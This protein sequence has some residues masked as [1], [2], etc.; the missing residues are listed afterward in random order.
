MALVKPVAPTPPAQRPSVPPL[1][2]AL[3]NPADLIAGMRAK[4]SAEAMTKHLQFLIYGPSGSGKTFSLRTAKTPILVD[5]FDPGGSLALADMVADGRALVVSEY[6]T[7]DAKHPT[8]FKAW[9]KNFDRFE[10]AGVF[11]KIGT[12]VLDSATTWGQAA[13]NEVMQRAGR[14]GG[15]PQQND[16]YPQMVLMEAAIK[17]IMALPCDVVFICHD[18]V[19]KDE[20]TGKVM[21]SPMLTGKA[22]KRIPLLFSEIYYADVK[23]TPKG[24]EYI[25]QVAKDSTNEARSRMSGLPGVTTEVYV[26][27]DFRALNAAFKREY[28]DLPNL[29]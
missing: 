27:Q 5:S 23:R 28:K 1:K 9:D 21:R 29:E 22:K 7:E 16:W 20:I 2:K 12:Y 26:P 13:L 11:E 10:K 3:E 19:M 24:T 15:V 14:A 17:R 4:Y 6:E 18:D 25:W 8:A